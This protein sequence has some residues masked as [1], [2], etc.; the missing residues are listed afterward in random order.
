MSLN[1]QI[2]IIFQ[3]IL[4]VEAQGT[5][6]RAQGS[7]NGDQN[8]SKFK[9]VQV[10]QDCSNGSNMTFRLFDF[11]TY[12]FSHFNFQYAKS[13]YYSVIIRS[14]FE[15]CSRFSERTPNKIRTKS[16]RSPDKIGMNP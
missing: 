1:Y 6:L 7:G 2:I 12:I 3:K 15:V 10:V 16:E 11:L 5:E 8:C 4:F 13:W 9:V 14:S